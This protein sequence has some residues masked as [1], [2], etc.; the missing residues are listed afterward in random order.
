MFASI[1][2]GGF[3]KSAN[4]FTRK[5]IKTPLFSYTTLFLQSQAT[6]TTK[7]IIKN[8]KKTTFETPYFET[9]NFPKF[10]FQHPNSPYINEFPSGVIP[11]IEIKDLHDNPG[12]RKGKIIL[13]RGIG[14]K[15]GKTS[16]RG[17]KGQKSRSGEL[18][19]FF[20]CLLLAKIDVKSAF[21][22][23]YFEN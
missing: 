10:P 23:C 5:D 13:G 19:L 1:L 15:K 11:S 8:L 16:G 3:S 9:S 14:S 18:L 7:P 17:H 2:N 6:K 22:S 4:K 20:L 21:F 12:S